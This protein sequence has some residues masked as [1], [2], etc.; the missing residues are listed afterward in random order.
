MDKSILFSQTIIP[1]ALAVLGGIAIVALP[2][3]MAYPTSASVLLFLISYIAPFA[4][5]T[6][7]V[8]V[9]PVFAMWPAS[10]VPTPPI[11][12]IWGGASSCVA[13]MLL[14]SIGTRGNVRHDVQTLAFA[15]TP[16]ALS[17]MLYAWLA[18]R[19]SKNTDSN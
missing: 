16:G 4:Y 10:R 14:Y 3:L 17:G 19:R 8:L 5:G 2:P 1:L 9:L 12:A 15:A 18:R 13:V 7:A 11:A 6:A